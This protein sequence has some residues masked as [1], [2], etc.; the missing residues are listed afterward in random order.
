MSLSFLKPRGVQLACC[1]YC[2]VLA[3]WVSTSCLCLAAGSFSN[4]MANS[5]LC[6]QKALS[7]ALHLSCMTLEASPKGTAFGTKP[8][9]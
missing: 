7:R 5:V 4:S 6:L 1:R 3:R 8:G 9:N 2:V